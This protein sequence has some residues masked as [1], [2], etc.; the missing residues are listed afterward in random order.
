METERSNLMTVMRGREKK[1]ERER[2][3]EIGIKTKEM[4]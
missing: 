3:R 1:H 4:K 2:E